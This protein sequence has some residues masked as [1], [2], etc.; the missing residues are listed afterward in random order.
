[1]IKKSA[2]PED[3]NLIRQPELDYLDKG[4]PAWRAV[5]ERGEV[6]YV[7]GFGSGTKEEARAGLGS[8]L[9]LPEYAYLLKRKTEVHNAR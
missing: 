2:F 7:L 1:M 4:R 5:D 6:V 3:W 8:V 9:A